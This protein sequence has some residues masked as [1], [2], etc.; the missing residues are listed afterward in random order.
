MIPIAPGVR[1]Q[2]DGIH[3]QFA[4]GGGPGGQNVNKLNT[5]AELWIDL[6]RIEGMSPRALDRLRRLA[7]ARLTDQD[8]IHLAGD[9]ARTQGTN[10]KQIFQRLREMILAAQKEPK[11][12]RPTKPSRASRQRRLDSKRKRSELKADRAGKF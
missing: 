2:P 9:A 12:R 8:E 1:V 3:V 4:R 7:G 5:K 10:R 6:S 11:P